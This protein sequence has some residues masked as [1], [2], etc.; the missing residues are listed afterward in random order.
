MRWPDVLLAAVLAMG[1]SACATSSLELAP[2]APGQ[3]WHPATNRDGEIVA[4]ATPAMVATGQA[5][6]VL[7][8]NRALA[9][10]PPAP[11]E[12]DAGRTYALPD[13]I[14][15]AESSNPDTRIAWDEA[16]RAALAEG[17]ARSAYLPQLTASA[18]EGRQHGHARDA[19]SGLGADG[20]DSAHGTISVLSV[21]WLLFDF[22]ERSALVEAAR[23]V[24]VASNIAFTAAHQQVIHAVSASFYA[25]AAATARAR[26]AVQ[27]LDNAR[28]VEAAAQARYRQGIGTV[29]EVAQ[30]RQATA[31][32]EL[33]RVQA[34][35]GARDAYVALLTAVGVPPTSE[36]RIAELAERK[37]SLDLAR[38]LDDMIAA[39]L[40]RRPDVLGAYA[41]MKASQANVRAARA[42][43]RPKLFLA[44]T[45]S[46]GH[47]D[48]DVT[49]LPAAGQQP[50][51]VN[52]GGHHFGSAVFLGVTMPLYD[53]GTRSAMLARAQAASDSAGARL[54]QV[55]DEAARQVAVADNALRTSLAA[56]DAAEALVQA[57][58]ITF[59]AALAAYRRGVGT[60]TDVTLAQSQWLQ[61]R[62][63][64]SDARSQAL[65]AAATLAL[66]T[67]SLGA[68]PA[69]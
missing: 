35:G 12:L 69:W 29:V 24:S 53:G 33:A 4:G 26:T 46:Y 22:G 34:Q 17:I 14:D 8:A 43:S 65:T 25:H 36:L 54:A 62:N 42:E 38:P 2:P 55:R 64:R 47:G 3:P 66:V 15:L 13:L 39:A 10:L 61:A 5:G 52:V 41:A 58:G 21:Q 49:A 37:L 16:R 40:S 9:S 67:G 18:L 19:I 11:V 45:G 59:D 28:Q 56:C 6:Y 51:T 60:L 23:Q 57:A 68:A 20:S 30:A 1:L 50:P 44:A 63:A 31:A 27:A 7:P 32:A 48:L